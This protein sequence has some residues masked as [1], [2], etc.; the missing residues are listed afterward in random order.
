MQNYYDT[1]ISIHAPVKGATGGY[2][3]LNRRRKVFQSTHP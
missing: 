3:A 1:I 2:G